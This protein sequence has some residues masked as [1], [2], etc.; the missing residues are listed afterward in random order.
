[1]QARLFLLIG[2]GIPA[3]FQAFAHGK[4]GGKSGRLWKGVAAYKGAVSDRQQ[5]A[6]ARQSLCE[7][8]GDPKENIMLSY[9]E[10]KQALN[11][12]ED[13]LNEANEHRRYNEVLRDSNPLR[14][15]GKHLKAALHKP[16]HMRKPANERQ[17]ELHKGFAGR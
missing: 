13:L 12:H 8:P 16:A 11:R 17:P 4:S 2:S 14:K 7:E 6:T 1:L 10:F 9:I 3:T 15:L 5:Q